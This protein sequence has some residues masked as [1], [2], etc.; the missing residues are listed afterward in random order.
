MD[1]YDC[2]RPGARSPLTSTSSPTGTCASG[3]RRFWE[4]DRAAFATLRHCLLEVSKLLAPFV[5]FLAD[6]IHGNLSGDGERRTRS[7]S[8]TSRRRTS[9]SA[10]RHWR[11]AWRRCGAPSSW[12]GRRGRL[13]AS[14]C[15]SR[16]AKAVI[17]AQ[18]AEREAIESM[19]ELVRSELNVK[20]L[21]FVSEEAELVSLRGQAELPQPRPAL[22][23]AD[24]EGRRRGRERSTPPTSPRRSRAS[25]GSGSTST[26]ASTSW[27][28]RT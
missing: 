15:A 22:R 28:P 5:P 1:D 14:R 16:C 19:G 13:P 6:E 4:G 24:A 21:E 27:S 11:L 17:V 2:T 18:G 8:P 26:D 25:G 9:R 23:Q 12:A 20:E 3:R 7:T 10:T